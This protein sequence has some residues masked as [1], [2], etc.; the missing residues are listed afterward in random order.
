MNTS[1]GGIC[2]IFFV[3]RWACSQLS[4]R[5]RKGR[6]LFSFFL[7]LGLLLPQFSFAQPVTNQV[8]TLADGGAGSLRQVIASSVP[9][10][11]VI[12]VT[13]GMIVLTS[14]SLILSNNLSI[15]GPGATNLAISGNKAGRVFTISPTATVKISG[16]TICNGLG[17]SGS[18]GSIGQGVAPYGGTGGDGAPGGGIYN[19]GTL[20]LIGCSVSN[21]VAGT[22]GEGGYGSW[23]QH[24]F[25]H[26][27]TGGNGGAGGGI[28]NAGTIVLTGCTINNNA[29][30]NG[31]RG[32][33]AQSTNSIGEAAT[34]GGNGGNG[35]DGGGCYNAGTLMLTNCTFGGNS[36]GN[37]GTIYTNQG[38]PGYSP[39]PG[40]PGT[41]GGLYSKGS[42][43]LVASTISGNKGTGVYVQSG[44]AVN[45]WNTLVSDVSGTVNSQGNN[46]IGGNPMLGPLTNNGGQTLSF[47]LLPGSPAIDA[48]DDTL[49]SLVTDQRGFPRDAGAHVDIGAFEL[50]PAAPPNPIMSRSGA[51][52]AI[53]WPVA[54]SNYVLQFSPSLLPPMVWTNVTDAVTTQGQSNQVILSP[55][56]DKGFYRLWHP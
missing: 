10:A 29:A 46:L 30:G 45:L 53:Q 21:N 14:G 40:S 9:G 34:Y 42:L 23:F 52:L 43:A 4:V 50:Q 1:S 49:A 47:A 56:G 38:P 48:G 22:G 27:G 12:F 35:G 19:A 28:Y 51:N 2:C 39:T 26:S 16:L 41:V 37:G 54:A 15:I 3:G 11:N 13:N 5:L 33:L 18:V 24:S 31:G 6:W 32:G 44:F 7:N 36:Y 8:T 17:A 25:G 20:S 55:A